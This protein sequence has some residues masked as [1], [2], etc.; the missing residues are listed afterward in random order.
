GPTLLGCVDRAG[1][2]SGGIAAHRPH[3]PA[4]HQHP[5]AHVVLQDQA[6]EYL[7]RREALVA[8]LAATAIGGRALARPRPARAVVSARVG[9]ILP[10]SKKAADSVPANNVLKA[11]HVWA[12]WVNAHGGVGGQHVVLKTYDSMAN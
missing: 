10:L 1:R 2:R 9:V 3:R 8:A 6:N 11:A 12:D 7:T 4:D 5:G